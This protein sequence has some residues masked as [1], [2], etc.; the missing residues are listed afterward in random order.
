M[1]IVPRHEHVRRLVVRA[2]RGQHLHAGD[3]ADDE[4]AFAGVERVA[5]EPAT[6]R[7]PRI[8]DRPMQLGTNHI[9]DFVFEA[10][11]TGVRKGEVVGVRADAYCAGRCGL[12]AGRDCG[13]CAAVVGRCRDAE[14]DDERHDEREILFA[15]RHPPSSQR[16]TPSAPHRAN[17]YNMPPLVVFDGK[18]FIALT[19][20]SAAEE[21]RASRPPATMAP[22]QPPMPD[23][24]ATY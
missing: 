18:S 19:K 1:P 8:R 4:V 7:P 3:G 2:R 5:N 6:L 11:A 23:S 14:Q 16:P 13:E 10:G 15:P 17:T 22:Y 24:T 20:P 12:G 21:S 9:G